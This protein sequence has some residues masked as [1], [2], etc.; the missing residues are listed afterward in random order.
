[1]PS[2]SPPVT[3]ENHCSVIYDNTLYV[4]SPK[5]FLKLPLEE[6]AEWSKLTNGVSVTGA[7]CNLGYLDGNSLKPALWVVGGTSSIANYPGLQAYSFNDKS[8]ESISPLVQVTTDRVYHGSAFLNDSSSILVYAGSQTGDTTLSSSTFL[9]STV[10]PYNVQSFSSDAPPGLN[11]IVMPFNSS[12]AVEMGGDSSN[13]EIFTFDSTNGWVNLNVGV[14]Q[15]LENRSKVQTALIDGSDGSKILEIFSMDVS[16]NV[17]STYALID[18]N[19]DVASWGDDVGSSSS[20]SSRFLAERDLTLSNFPTYNDSYAPD[21]K[22]TNFSMAQSSSGLI[23]ISGGNSE[24]SL[25]MFNQTGNTW[26]NTTHF[27]GNSATV[28][29]S[30][31][32]ESSSSSTSSSSPAA[33]SS[34]SSTTTS[35][36]AAAT[37]DSSTT[38]LPT[39]TILGA[40]LGTIFGIAAMLVFL[41]ILLK[42]CRA[43]KDAALHK[44]QISY[45]IENKEGMD[46]AD[47]GVDYMK[48]A[49]GAPGRR[50]VYS[51]SS[52]DSM[53][54]LTGRPR[55]RETK[56]FFGR[57]HSPASIFGRGKPDTYRPQANPDASAS[58]VTF[59]PELGK[60]KAAA[61]GVA[62]TEPR[63]NDTGWSKYFSTASAHEPSNAEAARRSEATSAYLD[64]TPSSVHHI[65]ADIPPLKIA[66]AASRQH[67]DS[68]HSASPTIEHPS[69]DGAGLALTEGMTARIS[70]S[71]VSMHSRDSDDGHFNSLSPGMSASI[72]EPWT[73]VDAAN[74]WDPRPSSSTYDLNR[75]TEYVIPLTPQPPLQTPAQPRP[76]SSAYDLSR[77]GD[78][79]GDDN[80]NANPNRITQ[81]RPSSSAYDLSRNADLPK[82]GD[83]DV[84]RASSVARPAS[85]AYDISS[86]YGDQSVRIPSFPMPAMPA[87]IAERQGQGVRDSG[88]TGGTMWPSYESDYGSERGDYGGND[89]QDT[90]TEGRSGPSRPPRPDDMSWLNLGDNR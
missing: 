51:A 15:S 73:P 56:S 41:L 66:V 63:N 61:T 43:K 40:T 3:L 68:V 13:Y 2:P 83:L 33:S 53:A 20:S 26:L 84:G 25:S 88:A 6:D 30:K 21:T 90:K 65:S 14:V 39:L 32:T 29:D 7:T 80:A 9:I 36:D 82:D 52:Q 50:Q 55:Y 87:A 44:R 54:I 77:N 59:D 69:I 76:S 17:V 28:T 16:P 67:F 22:R 89:R 31:P 10:S 46:F 78:L 27:F 47:R 18:A 81:G 8:W 23:V 48:E 70:T 71:S 42:W 12:H 1:M 11:P 57:T 72:Q 24:D 37:S 35:S 34:S 64:Y 5:A 45:P 75:N 86:Y 79:P 19:G 4:Y 38:N 49:E 62:R 85:S 74:G 58:K 60:P